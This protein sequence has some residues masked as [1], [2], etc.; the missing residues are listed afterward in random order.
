MPTGASGGMPPDA[1]RGLERGGGVQLEVHRYS[2]VSVTGVSPRMTRSR[3][4]IN[5]ASLRIDFKAGAQAVQFAVRHQRWSSKSL[6][7][8]ALRSRRKPSSFLA[9]ADDIQQEDAPLA[10][11]A[12]AGAGGDDFAQALGQR[13]FRA[14]DDACR[15]IAPD[16]PAAAAASDA[17]KRRCCHW[18][19]GPTEFPPA[20]RRPSPNRPAVRSRRWA[21]A[22]TARRNPQNHFAAAIAAPVRSPA[23]ACVVKLE[24]CSLSGFASGRNNCS[25]DFV[26]I[27]SPSESCTS[28]R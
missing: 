4:S 12:G 25:P 6:P 7:A 3:I 26:A 9:G 24:T 27:C 14:P 2:Q 17:R 20:R 10:V 1:A 11:D 19:R 22:H 28:G 15:R 5:S 18:F 23:A 21:G 13:R 8:E 16:A